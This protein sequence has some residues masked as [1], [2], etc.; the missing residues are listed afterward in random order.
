[1]ST[2]TRKKK[3]RELVISILS[4]VYAKRLVSNVQLAC[5]GFRDVVESGSSSK[6]KPEEFGREEHRCGGGTL[7]ATTPMLSLLST[8]PS[9]ATIMSRRLM[10]VAGVEPYSE[11]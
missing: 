11:H 3:V 4:S 7:V 5:R 9:G 6:T 10:R 8:R 2:E 1:M